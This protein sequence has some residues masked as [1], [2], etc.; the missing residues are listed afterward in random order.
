MN[1]A[2]RIRESLTEWRLRRADEQLWWNASTLHDVGELTAQWLEGHIRHNP[3][4]PGD[5]PDPETEALAL[6][7]AAANR[8]GYVTTGSQPGCT[9]DAW[10]QRAAVE[11]LVLYD[12]DLHRLQAA[13]DLHG[14][15]CQSRL[16]PRRMDYSTAITVTV[17]DRPDGTVQEYTGFGVGISR[18]HMRTLIFSSHHPDAVRQACAAW[19]VT[20]IDPDWDRNTNLIAALAQFSASG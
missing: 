9:E 2:T 16:A 12:A 5:G 20:I 11:G 6:P 15:I 3:S 7:L 17:I 4:Y 1:I 8:A 19:Q 18:H 10:R 14:L 13:A